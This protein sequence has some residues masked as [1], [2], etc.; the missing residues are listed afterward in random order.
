MSRI[1]I[2]FLLA[3]SLAVAA[4]FAA[5]G[6]SSDSG[7]SDVP[8]QKVLDQ[9]FSSKSSI[10]SGKM[11]ASLKV[12]VVAEMIETEETAVVLQ[13]LGVRFGQGWH[14]SRAEAEPTLRLREPRLKRVG[15]V[16]AWG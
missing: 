16:E 13:E 3:T 11:D 1:R 10:D 15:A 12:E 14:F 7:S 4:A 8:P 6:G 5:C 9:T 2:L